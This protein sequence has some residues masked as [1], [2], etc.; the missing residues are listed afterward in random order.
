MMLLVRYGL[1]DLVAQINSA[2]ASPRKPRSG[3]LL[4]DGP[5][6]RFFFVFCFS[7]APPILRFQAF[8]CAGVIGMGVA[9]EKQNVGWARQSINRPT[10]RVL[11][12]SATS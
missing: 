4:I 10:L 2:D 12:H 5:H 7:A 3:V 1:L 9:A 6:P 8:Q 11:S